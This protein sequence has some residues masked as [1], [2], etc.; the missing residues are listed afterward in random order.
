MISHSSQ[1]STPGFVV[2]PDLNENGPPTL[3]SEPYVYAP[4]PKGDL[5]AAIIKENG[6]GNK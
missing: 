6:N 3:I 2:P 4:D 1:Y 5:R